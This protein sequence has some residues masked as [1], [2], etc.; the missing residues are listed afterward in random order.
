MRSIC[1]HFW[2]LWPKLITL[3]MTKLL[4]YSEQNSRNPKGINLQCCEKW[5]TSLKSWKAKVFTLHMN[6][7]HWP[8]PW[9]QA[10]CNFVILILLAVL[11]ITVTQMPQFVREAE[12]VMLILYWNILIRG[13]I[14]GLIKI[15]KN[16]WIVFS[17]LQ[18]FSPYTAT[19]NI[20]GCIN[21]VTFFQIY[22]LIERLVHYIKLE[23]CHALRNV[24]V[25]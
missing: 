15:V 7:V 22:L 2:K 19:S 4:I 11:A 25:S 21:W 24:E 10:A 6:L 5:R 18:P 14:K 1:I 8:W 23:S 17:L 16:S 13:L 12:S 20:H 9:T 3:N